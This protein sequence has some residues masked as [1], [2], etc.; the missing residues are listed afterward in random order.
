MTTTLPADPETIRLAQQ[1][2]NARG[3]SVAA[4]VR[5]AITAAAGIAPEALPRRRKSP[6]EIGAAIDAIVTEVQALPL[7]DTRSDD[8]ILGYDEHGLPS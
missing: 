4:V 2:A 8:E 6:A 3:Q 1:L 7:L 5:A